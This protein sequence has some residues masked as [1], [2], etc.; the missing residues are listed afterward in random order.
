MPPITP[1]R[2]HRSPG[3]ASGARSSRNRPQ[4]WSLRACSSAPADCG[5]TAASCSTSP[6]IRGPSTTPA[7]THEATSPSTVSPSAP[8]SPSGEWRET[9]SAV[10]RSSTASSSPAKARSST[11]ASCQAIRASATTSRTAS[12]RRIVASCMRALLCEAGGGA[13][14]DRDDRARGDRPQ[15]RRAA[16]APAQ[17]DPGPL[18]DALGSSSSPLRRPHQSPERHG[19][20]PGTPARRGLGGRGDALPSAAAIPVARPSCAPRRPRATAREAAAPAV[21]GSEGREGWE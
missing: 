9:K 11:A 14:L 15:R 3:A 13:V 4:G 16:T 17:A 10:W 7:R 5:S 1:R 20:T 8:V 2:F 6:A 18:A 19:P 12:A 21:G